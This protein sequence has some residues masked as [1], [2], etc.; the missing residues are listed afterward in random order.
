MKMV[1]SLLLGTAAGLVAVAGAQAADLPVKAKPVEYVKICSVYGE[2][3]FYIPGTDT[4][5]K[6]G[7]YVRQNFIFGQ[8]SGSFAPRALGST[9]GKDNPVDQNSWVMQS[10]FVTSVDVR[11]QTEYG[12]LRAF[13][14]AGFRME[15]ENYDYGTY[16]VERAFIQLGGWT[17]G[18]TTSFFDFLSGAFGYQQVFLAGGATSAGGRMLG[19]Y[20]WSFGNGVSWTSSIEDPTTKRNWAWDAGDFKN[21]LTLGGIPGPAGSTINGYTTCGSTLFFGSNATSS[22][23]PAG[24]PT[25]VGCP[26]GDYA[27]QKLPDFVSQFRVDQAWGSAQL[28]TGVHQISTGYYGNNAKTADPTFTGVQPADKYGFAIVGGL[29]LNIGSGGD[30]FYVETVYTQGAPGYAGLSELD[31]A[32]STWFIMRDNRFSAGW[33]PDAVFFNSGGA[34]CAVSTTTGITACGTNPNA[35]PA[36]SGIHLTTVWTVAAAYEHYWTPAVRTSIYGV[37]THV[38]FDNTAKLA[39]CDTISGVNVN[40]NIG[41]VA[42]KLDASTGVVSPGCNPNFNVWGVGVRTI[43]NPVKNL[44]VGLEV[45]RDELDQK[46][47][48]NLI[49]GAFTGSGGQPG[50]T[51]RPANLGVWGAMLRVQRNFYP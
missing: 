24:T 30:K 35:A 2:G 22:L 13:T 8:A 41:V 15:S 17:F 20:T 23:F 21:T 18:R 39:F 25:L 47:D 28:A 27:Q 40:P 46:Y 1:K 11:T 12:T 51:Y 29:S 44:D 32:N 10:T 31:L 4:C 38:T 42:G 16:Y 26:I 3:F 43:W 7:G 14:R 50:G 33:A 48:P 36:F 5:I 34:G 19:A 6:L 49:V 37:Y 45:F 9:G